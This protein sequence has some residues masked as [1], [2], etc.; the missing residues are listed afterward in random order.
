MTAAG[1]VVTPFVRI[2]GVTHAATAVTAQEIVDRIRK[3]IGVEWGSDDVDTFKAGD[4]S[5]VVTGIV[6]TSMATLDV[7]QK[8]VQ[9]GANLII[10]AAP[11]FYSRA[12]LA[13]PAGR[14]AGAGR[15]QAPPRGGGSAAA[16][17]PSPATVSGPGTGASA[18]MPPA[19]ALPQSVVPAPTPA[20][21]GSAAAPAD[22]VVAGK[23]AFIDKH[24][25]VV[26]R[27]TQHWNQRTP[28]P[29][30]Q[31]LA[32]AMGWKSA[33]RDPR[34]A[35]SNGGLHYEVPALRLD[36]LASQLK[37]ALGTRGGIRAVGDRSLTVR[38]IGL[39]P[40]YTLIQAAIAMLPSVD[41]IVTGEVQEW[42]SATYAQDV[43]FAGIRKGFI[44]V[45]RV[46]NEAPGMQVCADWLK[47]IVSEVP[48]RFIS[49]G[50]P[51]WRPL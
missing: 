19:P 44:S 3:N 40:G 7:L 4:P 30:A 49:A 6:T 10:T 31:G 51:Y 9:T 48:V 12:D 22:P 25:L 13:T 50:D 5:T 47:T 45:G 1:A 16:P 33:G 18:P 38:T 17:A 46:V 42:E 35:T 23:L 11:T 27:L 26:F 2:N 8:A 37:K 29:R 14:G 34:S 21:T 43:A 36:A 28:D 20:A 41:V 15:G 24:K 32:T 39:L